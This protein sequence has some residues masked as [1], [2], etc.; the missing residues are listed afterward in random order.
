MHGVEVGAMLHRSRRRSKRSASAGDVA[1][2]LRTAAVLACATAAAGC[3][4]IV[5]SFSGRKEACEIVSIGRPAPATVVRLVDTGVTINNDPVVEF[6]L[7]VEPPGGT[8]YEARSQALVSRLDVPAVQ[9][10]RVFPVKVDP[11]QP[12]RVAI[13]LWD[14]P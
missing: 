6:V 9:P 11:Q 10:G 3:A 14:C 4:S 2:V 7:R 8:P 1:R 12:G 5:D 13:D